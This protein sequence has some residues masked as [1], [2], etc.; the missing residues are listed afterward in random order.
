MIIKKNAEIE[1]IE[2]DDYIENLK[3]DMFY[4]GDLEISKTINIYLI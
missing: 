2:I 3:I 4:D 1:I